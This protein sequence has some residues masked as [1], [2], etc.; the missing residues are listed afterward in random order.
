MLKKSWSFANPILITSFND[1]S[2]ISSSDKHG[3]AELSASKNVHSV[4][5]LKYNIVYS[6]LM[7]VK[8]PNYTS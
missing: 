6:T 8:N 4:L 7:D 1:Y 3:F 5:Q 2:Y